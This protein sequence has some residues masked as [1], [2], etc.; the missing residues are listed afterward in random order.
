MKGYRKDT[1]VN[2]NSGVISACGGYLF[3][4]TSDLWSLVILSIGAYWGTAKLIP[5]FRDVF[6]R[7]NLFGIDLCKSTGAPV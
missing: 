4:M 5:K 2:Y 6:I 1:S 3:K 7:A